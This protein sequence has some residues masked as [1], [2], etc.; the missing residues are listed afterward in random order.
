[1][2]DPVCLDY[3]LSM[4]HPNVKVGGSQL[5]RSSFWMAIF[6]KRTVYTFDF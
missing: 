5:F 4:I 2:E 1:M 3:S 6:E